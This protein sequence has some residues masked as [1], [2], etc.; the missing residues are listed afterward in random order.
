MGLPFAHA[1]GLAAKYDFTVFAVEFDNPD[2]SR[3]KFVRISR[4]PAADNSALRNVPYAGTDLL[5]HVPTRHH[6]HFDLVEKMEVLTF[7]GSV[8]YVHFCYRAY[9]SRHWSQSRQPGVRECY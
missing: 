2:P 7:L 9:L 8:S 5:R 1:R 6:A 4:L 3:I